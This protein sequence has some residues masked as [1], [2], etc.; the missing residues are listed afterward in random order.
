MTSK[1]TKSDLLT[2]LESQ[3]Q[4]V[5]S[6]EHA[7]GVA[8]DQAPPEAAADYEYARDGIKSLIDTSKAAIEKMYELAADSESP[9]AFE[10]LN[11]MIKSTA[12]MN[13]QLLDILKKKFSIVPQ[14]ANADRGAPSVTNN[15]IFVGT[16]TDL[17]KL[18]KS[19]IVDV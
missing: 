17:Q 7:L 16:T 5:K 15:A 10:V 8:I 4:I 3:A 1:K 19:N 11:A 14:T 9:R 13:E 2:N 12:E 18:I 6:A